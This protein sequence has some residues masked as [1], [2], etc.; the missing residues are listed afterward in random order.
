MIKIKPA[1]TEPICE[2]YYKLVYNYMI[3]DAN[4]NTT[5]D[6]TVSIE[7]PYVERYISLINSLKP[8][9]GRWGIVFERQR[10]RQHFN[11]GQLSEDD[12]NFLNKMMFDE[13][14]FDND[15]E[16]ETTTEDEYTWQFMEGV[17]G[18]TEYSFLVF[19]GVDLL[20]VDCFGVEHETIIVK[21]ETI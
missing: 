1:N 2:P 17:R 8:I 18:E 13:Y 19:E 9:R 15:G 21:D 5:Y 11:E 14:D 6:T 3:G 20:Y 10:L 7:N 4:G 16:V 12:Y